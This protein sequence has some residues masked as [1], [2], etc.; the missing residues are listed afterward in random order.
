MKDT[1]LLSYIDSH[2]NFGGKRCTAAA[3]RLLK[4]GRIWLVLDGEFERARE[5]WFF[6]N[7]DLHPDREAP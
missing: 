5:G 2:T 7:I 6:S 4:N 1:K 3:Y